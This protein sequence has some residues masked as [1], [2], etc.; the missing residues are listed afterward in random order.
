MPQYSKNN[1]EWAHQQFPQKFSTAIHPQ[2]PKLNL[3]IS[4]LPTT[5][6]KHNPVTGF[7]QKIIA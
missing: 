3:S 6:L 5:F 2:K 7:T 4:P 1:N